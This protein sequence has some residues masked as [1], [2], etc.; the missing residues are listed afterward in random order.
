MPV[1]IDDRGNK[2]WKDQFYQLHRV[3]G[4]AIEYANGNKVWYIRGNLHRSDGP[5]VEWTNGY[6]AWYINGDLH[7]EDG[8]AIEMPDGS[9]KWF[10]NGVLQKTHSIKCDWLKEGF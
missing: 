8:P 7:R 5:A 10:I 3:N 6:K 4:P 9:R 2:V 1:R